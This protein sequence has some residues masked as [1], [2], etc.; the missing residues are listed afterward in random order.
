MRVVR[1]PDIGVIGVG[2][3]TTPQFPR[4]LFE[5]LKITKKHFYSIANPTWKM[6]IHF[7]W[8]PR[9]SFEYTFDSALDAQWADLP[10]L[11]GFYCDEDFSNVNLQG[12]LMSQGKVSAR[13]PNNGGP[14]IPNSYAF[15]LFNPKLVASLEVVAKTLGVEFIDG[16]TTGAIPGANGIAAVTLEDGRQLHADF[17]VDASGFRSELLGRALERTVH[18]LQQVA[19]LRPR[20]RGGAGI[21]PGR[22]HPAVHDR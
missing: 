17:F 7:L 6:G 12:A 14:E 18:F 21:A 15:H 4:F 3:S 19:F 2:E 1:S 22:T 11:N 10:R 9:K 8:G 5:Y 16:K 20:D 13:Q